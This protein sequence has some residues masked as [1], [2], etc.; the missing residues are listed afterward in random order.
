MSKLVTFFLLAIASFSASAQS[1][2]ISELTEWSWTKIGLVCGKATDE[3][4]IRLFL[5]RPDPKIAVTVLNFSREGRFDATLYSSLLC[6]D[7]TADLSDV[8]CGGPITNTGAYQLNGE[9]LF[10]EATRTAPSNAW[11]TWDAFDFRLEIRGDFLELEL[12]QRSAFCPN[13]H[14]V[15]I[16]FQ[17]TPSL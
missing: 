8:F 14:G 10:L 1:S 4:R 6:K 2:K 17:K 16:Y 9:S 3:S 11:G 13:Q 7:K 15:F 5:N 12:K